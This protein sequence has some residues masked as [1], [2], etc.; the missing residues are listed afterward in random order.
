MNILS[1]AVKFTG[2]DGKIEISARLTSGSDLRLVVA[3]NGVGVPKDK[4]KT[5][6]QPFVQLE[7]VLTKEHKGSGLGL[8]LV[9]KLMESYQGTVQMTSK[10]GAGTKMILIFPKKRVMKIKKQKEQK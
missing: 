4:I 5:L 3:D 1:N 7:N 8:V 10:L 2:D 9:K 6:F